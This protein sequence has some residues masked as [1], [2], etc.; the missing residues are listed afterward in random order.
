M[1]YSHKAFSVITPALQETVPTDLT[2]Q[3]AM[4]TACGVSMEY[5]NAVKERSVGRGIIVQD[6]GFTVF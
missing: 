1:G 4:D 3:V 5:V 6:I 2:L